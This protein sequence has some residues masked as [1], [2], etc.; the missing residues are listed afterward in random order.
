M[1][2]VRRPVVE[3]LWTNDKEERA[4]KKREEEKNG[5]KERTNKYT[6]THILI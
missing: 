3:L 2:N 5:E 6:H 4:A 1:V